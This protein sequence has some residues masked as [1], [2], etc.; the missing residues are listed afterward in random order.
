MIFFEVEESREVVATSGERHDPVAMPAGGH[1][2]AE[3]HVDAPTLRKHATS[4]DA[5]GE[6]EA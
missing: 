3:R 5:I 4:M 1:Q 2:G 6:R